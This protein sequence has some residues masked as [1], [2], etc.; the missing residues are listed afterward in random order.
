VS[1]KLENP[2]AQWRTLRLG[3]KES[4]N[5]EIPTLP[6]E[7]NTSFGRVRYALSAAKEARVLIPISGRSHSLNDLSSESLVVKL[8]KL[9]LNG[10]FEYYADITCTSQKLEGVFSDVIIELLNRINFGEGSIEALKGTLND[11]RMLFAESSSERPSREIVCGLIGELIFL[12]KLLSINSDAWQT[13]RGPLS[14]RHDFR[15]GT[16]AIEVKSTQRK[17]NKSISI[18][19]IEQ[20]QPPINGKL[21]I[22]HI[23]LEEVNGGSLSVSYLTQKILN[24]ASDR[25]EVLRRLSIIGCSNT[26]SSL[27]NHFKFQLEENNYYIVN[28]TFPKILESSFKE[29]AIPAGISKIKYDIDLT[30]SDASKLDKNM[31]SFLLKELIQCLQNE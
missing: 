4:S 27:W 23:T 25:L 15:A 18:S 21:Y 22:C 20:L 11:F 2:L 24:K 26:E 7:I 8:S 9:S 1:D 30:M 17:G 6:S 19:S 31:E 28:E 14:E 29:N 16:I 13:W 12:D 3:K 5:L 10:A